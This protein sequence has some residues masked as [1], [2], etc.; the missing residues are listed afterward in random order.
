MFLLIIKMVITKLFE[1]QFLL[2]DLCAIIFMK[3]NDNSN[4][5]IL[6]NLLTAYQLKSQSKSIFNWEIV[7][8]NYDK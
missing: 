4:K 5:N 1:V 6:F 3:R 7:C 8:A 2:F